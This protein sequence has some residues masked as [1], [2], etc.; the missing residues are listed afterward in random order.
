[1]K[2]AI[3]QDK[4]MVITEVAE[5]VMGEGDVLVKIEAAALNRADLLQK[6][7]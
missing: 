4:K 6:Q 1:M 7:G 5:P 3:V 2:A